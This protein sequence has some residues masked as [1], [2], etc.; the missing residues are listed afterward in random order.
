M[1][2]SIDDE[3]IE[4]Y[5]NRKSWGLIGSNWC[6]KMRNEDYESWERDFLDRAICYKDLRDNQSNYLMFCSNFDLKELIDIKPVKGSV[7]VKS[8]CE[9]FDVEME[10][11]WERVMNWIEHFGMSVNSTHV[12]GHASRNELK[13]FVEQVNPKIIIPIHT[14]NPETYKKWSKNV[15]I[16]NVGDSYSL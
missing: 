3:N 5:A 9:P 13:D 12:S 1:A 6:R 4:L 7:Y 15:N 11:D 2:P 16:L 8:V 10:M 14:E